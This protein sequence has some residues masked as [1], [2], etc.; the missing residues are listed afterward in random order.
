MSDDS[1]TYTLTP[2]LLQALQNKYRTLHALRVHATP[3]TVPR[4][5][6]AVLSTAFPGALR[7]LDRVPMS[8]L[9]A[10]LSAIAAVLAGQT[11]VERW[12]VLQCAYHGFMRAV[13]R[14]R[15]GLLPFDSNALLDPDACL[16]ALGYVPASD[17]PALTQ[18]DAAA[19]AS[20]RKPPGGRLN[21]WVMAWVA[22]EFGVDV[23][24]VE[25]ALF[26]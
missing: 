18:F 16:Q 22:R 21:P 17:E 1:H 14:I 24:T 5:T 6:F 19:L 13:L 11:K 3:R 2:Q 10:R 12:M 9:E 20:I 25:D 26:R 15:R 4:A 23:A 7:E 8:V